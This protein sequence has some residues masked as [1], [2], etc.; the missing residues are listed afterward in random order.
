[1]TIKRVPLEVTKRADAAADVAPLAPCG[2]VARC[3]ARADALLA[4]LL[5]LDDDALRKLR[6][7]RTNDGDVVVLG[8]PDALPWFDGARYVG[9]ATPGLYVVTTRTTSVPAP[10]A[11]KALERHLPCAIVDDVIVPLSQ[12]LPLSR[13]GLQRRVDT[14]TKGNVVT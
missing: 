12:A 9:E 10:L 14:N 8:P 7:V 2:L 4:R 13:A 3:G 6:G 1:V 5:E 11:A